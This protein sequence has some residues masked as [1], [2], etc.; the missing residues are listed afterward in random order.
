M[1]GKLKAYNLAIEIDPHHDID[2]FARIAGRVHNVGV[3]VNI[4]EEAISPESGGRRRPAF[5]GA[6]PVGA[7]K[8]L[9]ELEF[10]EEFR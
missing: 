8:N 10:F 2:R 4:A 5:D 3:E 1:L 7:G 6:V 9:P